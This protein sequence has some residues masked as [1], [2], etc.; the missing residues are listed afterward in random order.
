M[1]AFRLL[2]TVLS[3]GTLFI[4]SGCGGG[5][6]GS[7]S[8]Q[9]KQLGLLSKKWTVVSQTSGSVLLGPTGS[10]A[11]STVHW[12]NFT[13]TITGTKGASSFSYSTS[14]QPKLSVWPAGGTWS[15]DSSS[16]GNAIVRDPGQVIN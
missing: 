15:F 10:Q 8:V 9:D 6:G 2:F 12:K 14:G 11:D 1:K 5:G 4:Y 16:P 13:L 3:L 7:E